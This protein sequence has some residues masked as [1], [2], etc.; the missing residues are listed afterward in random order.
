MQN[1]KCKL[2]V[3][4][5]LASSDDPYCGEYC[6]Q[7]DS[8]GSERDFC[9]CEHAGCGEPA[10][11]SP[12]F[13]V[14]GLPSSISVAPGRVLIEYSDQRHLRDQL[15]LLARRLQAEG[16]TVVDSRKPSSAVPLHRP[17]QAG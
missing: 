6:R 5:C 1:A 14:T 2:A 12:E 11:M 4:E 16:E 7:A 10:Q 9:Q 17:A 3:C 8:Q 15:V 13:D